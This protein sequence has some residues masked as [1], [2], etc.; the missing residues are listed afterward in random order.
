MRVNS[1]FFALELVVLVIVESEQ[2]L[3]GKVA[4]MRFEGCLGV[5]LL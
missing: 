4:I 2:I 3:G 1:H 5:F